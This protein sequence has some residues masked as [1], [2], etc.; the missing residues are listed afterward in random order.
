ML[1]KIESENNNVFIS[2]KP[3][4]GK[5]TLINKE[6]KSFTGKGGEAYIV[7]IHGEY[8]HILDNL[9]KETKGER[10]MFN[11]NIFFISDYEDLTINNKVTDLVIL[12]CNHLNIKINFIISAV[13]GKVLFNLYRETGDYKLISFELIDEKL[14]QYIDN[15]DQLYPLKMLKYL[16]NNFSIPTV[17]Y[18]IE[19][20]DNIVSYNLN[21]LL[22]EYVSFAIYSILD[23]LWCKKIDRDLNISKRIIIDD[24]TFIDD[25]AMFYIEKLMKKTRP[26]NAGLILASNDS[27][28]L[29]EMKMNVIALLSSSFVLADSPGSVSYISPSDLFPNCR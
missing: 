7:D 17:K 21:E 10:E 2:G 25:K 23:Q 11:S 3:G 6:I 24:L 8:H 1:R 22:E 28:N 15:Y 29:S 20:K 9:I 18:N 19:G 14:K 5:T 16:E 26:Y 13:L 4:T 12:L 27:E